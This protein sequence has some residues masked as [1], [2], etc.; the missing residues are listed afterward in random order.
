M[1]K[2]INNSLYNLLL[3]VSIIIYGDRSKK[4]FEV[5][6]GSKSQL[7]VIQINPFTGAPNQQWYITKNPDNTYN[8]K[9]VGSGLLVNVKR[10]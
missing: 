1:E 6:G 2:L 5:D 7:A 4:V 9:N 10:K 8:I 3:K